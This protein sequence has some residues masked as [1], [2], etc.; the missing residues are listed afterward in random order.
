MSWSR[1]SMQ[2]MSW[3]R[4]SMM[5][6]SWSRGVRLRRVGLGECDGDELV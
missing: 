2:E 4:E 5:E 1:E 3:S 6:M